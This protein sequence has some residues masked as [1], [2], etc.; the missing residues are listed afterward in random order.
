MENMKLVNAHIGR[1]AFIRNT[2][3]AGGGLILGFGWL[4]SCKPNAPV[5]V[6]ELEMPSEWYELNGY[7]KIGDNGV[8]TIMSP[9]PEIGQNV[10]TSMPMIVADELDMDWE[11]VIVEQ[12]PLKTEVFTWQVAG[13]SMSIINGWEPLRKAGATARQMLKTAA[14]EAWQVPLAEITTSEGMLYHKASGKSAHYG[15]M[16]SAAS[17]LEVPEEEVVAVGEAGVGVA[18]RM[19]WC[20][21]RVHISLHCPPP[22]ARHL[23]GLK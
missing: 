12:A 8:A 17:R 7:L 4:N 16:A 18:L 3:M 23:P 6:A 2:G 14:A 20:S 9:N 11:K 22:R 10:K 1:R 13:G 5:G 19:V 15:E 21:N